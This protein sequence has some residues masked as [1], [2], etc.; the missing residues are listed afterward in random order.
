MTLN[1]RKFIQN[2]GLTGV[3]L[4]LTL[5]RTNA[6]PLRPVRDLSEVRLTGSVK[7]EG[8]GIA[9]VAITDGLNV[10]TTNINGNYALKSNASAEFVYISTPRG[11]AFNHDKG[12]T[13]FYQSIVPVRGAFKADFNLEKLAIDDTIHNFIVW[14]DPQIQN[15]DDAALLKS[16][17]V[18]DTR[19]LIASYGEQ[20]LFHGI[21][22]G[23]LVWDKFELFPDY[24]EAV[25]QTGIPF[26]QVIG[27]HDM[28]IDARSDDNSSKTFKKH[29][30]PSYYS[31][32][33]GEVHYVVL[34]D[35]FFLGTSKSYIGY[36]QEQQFAWLEQDLAN[37]KPGSTVVVAVHIP[38]NTGVK[39]R[40]QLAEEPIGG[41]VANRRELYRILKPFKAHIMSGHTHFNEK[42]FEGGNI[43]EH[44][45]GTVCGAWWTGPICYDGTPNGY[46]VYEVNGGEITWYYKA[47]GMEKDHQFRIY[48]VG[49]VEG[50]PELFSVNVWNWD[51]EWKVEWFEDGKHRGELERKVAYD[52]WSIALHLG[53]QKPTR[54]AW[55]EPQRTDHMFFGKPSADARTI[56]VQ[57]TDRFKNVYKKETSLSALAIG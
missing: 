34:D 18:P 5:N 1:R 4:G 50:K 3:G 7:S 11:Y 2:L 35:V 37:V 49:A 28:D 52:P 33:R 48:P 27:N 17:S 20:A 55:V 15:A 40:N 43:I 13:Q 29:F 22:C 19:K 30:G 6:N 10:V 41:V 42:V 24:K 51:P 12:I 54:R 39:R 45:H 31:Y 44:V 46:G 57:V 36:I 26:F 47:V 53:D 8:K 32:N 38:V 9:G 14:A 23:D 21:G 16:Q 25:D 56:T